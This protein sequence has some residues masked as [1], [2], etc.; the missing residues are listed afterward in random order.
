LS[1]YDCRCSHLQY[2][3][4]EATVPQQ[5]LYLFSLPVP[6]RPTSVKASLRC[7]SNS[8]AVTWE[9][10]SGALSYVAVGVTADGS[11]R[12]EC[13]NTMTFCDLSDLQCGQTYNVSLFSQ[14]E[15]CSSEESDKARVQTGIVKMSFSY[16]ILVFL[17]VCSLVSWV[18]LLRGLLIENSFI[19]QPPALPRMWL[20]M[21]N[22]LKVAWLSPGLPTLMPSTSM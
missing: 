12:T 15:Y 14:D 17:V 20:L 11:H 10:A 4:C 13:N 6:C 22:V 3:H 21:L 18:E 8:A 7:H 19:P 9:R 5:I 16:M 2:G 1:V